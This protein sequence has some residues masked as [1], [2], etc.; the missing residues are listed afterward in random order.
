MFR[1]T[2]RFTSNI[3]I[4]AQMQYIDIPVLAVKCHMANINFLLAFSIDYQEKRLG[5]LIT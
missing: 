2:T 4:I 3:T 5:E 1:N